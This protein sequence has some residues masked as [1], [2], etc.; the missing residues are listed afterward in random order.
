MS[1]VARASL[2]LLVGSV[3]SKAL[4]FA[5]ELL[6]AYRY[7]AGEISDAFILTNSIPTILFVSLST[8]INI[9]YIPICQ[10][11]SD[12]KK[13]DRYTSNLANLSFT[14]MVIG[15][16]IIFCEPG[17]ILNLIAPGLNDATRRY[18]I[19][20]LRIVTF[21]IVPIVLTDLYNA[22]LQIN[23][24]FISTALYGVITNIVVLCFIALSDKESF[25]YLSLGTLISCIVGFVFTLNRVRCKTDYEYSLSFCPKDDMIKNTVYLTLPLIIEDVS[26]SLCLLVD[27]N[28][29]SLLGKGIISGIGYAGTIANVAASM[30]V[31]AIITST[32]PEL[33]ILSSE[34]SDASFLGLFMKYTKVI[35]CLLGPIS[36]F[37]VFFAHDIVTAIFEHGLFDSNATVIVSNSVICYSIGL[38]PMGLQSFVIRGFYALKN[39]KTPMM[40]KVVALLCNVIMNLLSY[41]YLGYKGIALSTSVSFVIA[42]ILLCVAFEKKSKMR[43]IKPIVF[44]STQVL[45]LSCGASTLVLIV[46]YQFPGMTNSLIKLIVEG[47]LFSSV[48][49]GFVFA[50]KRSF[51]IDIV[52]ALKRPKKSDKV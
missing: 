5:R 1:R 29:A 13:K 41:R 46:L 22:Y 8:A 44:E 10:G 32:Y 21:S 31:S 20:M 17:F 26:S 47:M 36:V 33:S 11:I 4:G 19:V 40:I 15:C 3:L 25:Y 12:K 52:S 2:L 18:A 9:S 48:M 38:L 16:I 7:G 24:C 6:V 27:R 50:F 49:F 42:L 28:I 34:A 51:I 35:C 23:R 39:T 43:I 37:F 14:I 45:G 30:I